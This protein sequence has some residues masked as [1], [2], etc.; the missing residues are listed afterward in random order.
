[1]RVHCLHLCCTKPGEAEDRGALP[2]LVAAPL[3]SPWVL[4]TF[5]EQPV[6]CL[7]GVSLSIARHSGFPE[8]TLSISRTS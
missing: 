7:A 6:Y 5:L 8:L 1:M 2:L 3:S 4:V